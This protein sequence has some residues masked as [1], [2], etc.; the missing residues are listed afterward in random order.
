M[1]GENMSVLFQ[2]LPSDG[3]KQA[4]NCEWGLENRRY[5]NL[6]RE[7][8][9]LELE[10]RWMPLDESM[11]E[12]WRWCRYQ[13]RRLGWI[14]GWKGYF[15]QRR[16]FAGSHMAFTH[17]EM[18][19]CSLWLRTYCRVSLFCW[20]CVRTSDNSPMFHEREVGSNDAGS[21]PSRTGL[22]S[23]LVHV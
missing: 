18:G 11:P 4:I 8:L 21:V 20:S 6:G 10:T 16:Q 15:G 1:W 13:L 5:G 2:H 17:L 7:D 3:G 22:A 9:T 23:M 14:E 19:P 12:F